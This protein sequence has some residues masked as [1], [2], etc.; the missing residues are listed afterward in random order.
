TSAA[1]VLAIL[2]VEDRGWTVKRPALAGGIVA[3]LL[4]VNYATRA[5]AIALLAAAIASELWRARRLRAYG[6]Y[7]MLFLG[8]GIVIYTRF[9]YD[10]RGQYGS[11]FVIDWRLYRDNF[12]YYLRMPASL[13]SASPSVLRYTLAGLMVS[14]AIFQMV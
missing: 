8:V 2:W 6:L 11:Q 3:A 1:A 10:S 12:L 5:T 7:L 4:L 13:W 9:I 14:G